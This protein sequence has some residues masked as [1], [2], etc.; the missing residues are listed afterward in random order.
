[1][2]NNKVSLMKAIEMSESDPA[3]QQL[4]LLKVMKDPNFNS[5]VTDNF[6]EYKE[7]LFGPYVMGKQSKVAIKGWLKKGAAEASHNFKPL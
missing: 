2:E 5:K 6:E 3:K 7:K 4:L 1:M